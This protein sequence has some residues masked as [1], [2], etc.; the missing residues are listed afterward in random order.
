MAEQQTTLPTTTVPQVSTAVT[1]RARGLVGQA[2]TARYNQQQRGE[3]V[4]AD[5]TTLW[6]AQIEQLAALTAAVSGNVN[7]VNVTS[8]TAA[9]T[10]VALTDTV[11]LCDATT[12]A[13]TVT[14][15]TAVGN[16]GKLFF[17]KKT[18]AGGNA[19]TIDG[20]GA[21]TID[22]AATKALAAQYDSVTI[23]SDG[24]NWMILD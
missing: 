8:K 13:F 21:E 6:M 11:I 18:D 19:V 15:P 23:V 14:L 20:N 16:S 24:T 1:S 10:A 7:S 12:A 4:K 2:S 5:E 17:V 9:Y 3:Q 22:G